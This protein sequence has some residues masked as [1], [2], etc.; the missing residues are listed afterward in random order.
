MYA[1]CT[2]IALDHIA[3]AWCRAWY[4]TCTHKL[5]RRSPAA[6]R[7]P[8]EA[9]AQQV[10]DSVNVI[11]GYLAARHPPCRRSADAGGLGAQR[12]SNRMD[13]VHRTLRRRVSSY[14]LH[15]PS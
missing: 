10:E 4:R 5:E 11:N 2:S 13:V 6:A 8:R 3:I 9:L 12:G 7:N 14:R 1:D 15:D